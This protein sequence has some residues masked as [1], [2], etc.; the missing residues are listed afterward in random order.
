MSLCAADDASQGRMKTA[1]MNE[2]PM[3]TAAPGR[4]GQFGAWRALTAVPA[5]V[6]SLLLLVVLSGG[7]GRWQAPVLLGWLVAGVAMFT[8]RGER[9]AVR[10]GCGFHRPSAAQAATL[11]P[12]WTTALRQSGI[13]AGD[14]DLY[15][16]RDR[17]PNAY[18]VGGHCV[19]VTTGIVDQYLAR[20]LAA[21]L[22]VA[23]LV[24]ELGHHHATRATRLTLLSVWLAA[25]WRLAARMLLRFMLAV[26]GRQP[27]AL[28]VLVVS[29]GVIVAVVQAV[30][31]RQ[32]LIAGVLAGVAVLTVICPLVDAAASR[33]GEL[34]ADRFAAEHGLAVPLAAALRTLDG[35]RA[36]SLGWARRAVAPHPDLDRRIDTLMAAR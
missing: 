21:D 19:A 27:R 13:A 7:L 16:K 12:L 15:V 6:G 23:V 2:P 14:V 18:T 20:R 34:A 3:P 1:A 11:I 30:Q 17:Q 28:S 10:V 9:I 24:H 22:L 4:S 29:A 5:M 25:P 32:W 31:Q 8:R 33:R 26:F 35:G 36:S